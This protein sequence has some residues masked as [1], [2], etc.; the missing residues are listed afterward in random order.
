VTKSEFKMLVG[1]EPIEDT[2][3]DR[4]GIVFIIETL[5]LSKNMR[6][7]RLTDLEQE[8]V[9]K[10]VRELYIV[11]ENLR[12]QGE[13]YMEMSDSANNIIDKHLS[14]LDHSLDAKGV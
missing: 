14:K 12:Y 7:K 4:V 9:E 2:F 8:P 6:D 10:L 13:G 5:I 11:L 3:I 1:T